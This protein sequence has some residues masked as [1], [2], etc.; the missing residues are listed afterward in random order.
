MSILKGLLTL[1]EIDDQ[2]KDFNYYLSLPS[3]KL[4]Y[5]FIG[6][7]WQGDKNLAAIYDKCFYIRD[8]TF[9]VNDRTLTLIKSIQFWYSDLE[10]ILEEVSGT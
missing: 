6:G 7:L 8:Y 9:P 3:P 1:R 10:I 4:S 5:G 2:L